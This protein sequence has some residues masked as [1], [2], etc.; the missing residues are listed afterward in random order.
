[1]FPMIR[2]ASIAAVALLG[3]C[4]AAGAPPAGEWEEPEAYSF[5][6]DSRCG[7]RTLFGRFA[8]D[9][10][11]G[12]VVAFRGL[13]MQ[14]RAAASALQPRDLPTLADLLALVAD[15]R[16]NGADRVD[17]VTDPVDAHPVSVEIDWLS[18][19]IDDEEC[20]TTSDV[21]AAG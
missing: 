16:A 8:I 7:E 15:A 14:G 2:A 11:S 17:L 21:A 6:L 3:A 5:I 18:E 19:A 9:V 4:S 13:D 1:M 12:D 20:Y 10:E